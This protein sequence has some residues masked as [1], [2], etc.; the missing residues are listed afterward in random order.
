[1]SRF[2]SDGIYP[3]NND[4]TNQTASARLA[5]VPDQKTDL[6]LSAR[7]GD[8][9]THFP[10]DFAGVLADTHQFNTERGLTLSFDG[11][12]QLS[13]K[14]ALRALAGL[15]DSKTGFD[16]V[17]DGPGDQA[18]F[19]FES[20]RSGKTTRTLLDLRT[21]IEAS[22]APASLLISARA[23]ADRLTAVSQL[24]TRSPCTI[25]ASRRSSIIKGR[26]PRARIARTLRSGLSFAGHVRVKAG[27]SGMGGP[28][29]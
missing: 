6:A 2:T 24:S 20:H 19:G 23:V 8:S 17:P 4:Y 5:L 3:Y 26:L 14:V 29:P 7:F 18:G 12:R 21:L 13:S 1:M 28:F 27:A 11:G 16:D 22:R 15:F 10:T 25:S 9:E